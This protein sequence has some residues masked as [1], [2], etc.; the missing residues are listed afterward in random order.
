M[1]LGLQ[2]MNQDTKLNPFMRTLLDLS[3]QVNYW[4]SIPHPLPNKKVQEDNSACSAKNGNINITLFCKS[5]LYCLSPEIQFSALRFHYRAMNNKQEHT[6][7]LNSEVPLLR[8]KIN[9]NT[10]AFGTAQTTSSILRWFQQF[11]SVLFLP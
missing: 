5:L 7:K 1:L 4:F 9:R 6:D 11:P 2:V 10:Q 8:L 3:I